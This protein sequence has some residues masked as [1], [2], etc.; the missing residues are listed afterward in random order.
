MVFEKGSFMKKISFL[1]LVLSLSF[2]SS[3]LAT[4]TMNVIEDNPSFWATINREATQSGPACLPLK[5]ITNFTE[6]N[7]A[8]S[9]I[10]INVS[11]LDK[12]ITIRE[13]QL[14]L[15]GKNFKA[16]EIEYKDYISG[17]LVNLIFIQG[18]DIREFAPLLRK[19]DCDKMN[20]GLGMTESQIDKLWKE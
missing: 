1:L 10:G 18:K 20:K 16:D 8:G 3:V 14:Y 2:A 5:T 6:D 13:L 11:V 4:K 9:A 15:F 12:P 17:Q 19:A 7:V